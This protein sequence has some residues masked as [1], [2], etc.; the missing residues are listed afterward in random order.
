LIAVK[1]A[2]KSYQPE[3]ALFCPLDLVLIL[4][5]PKKRRQA[6]A[7]PSSLTDQAPGSFKPVPLSI[8]FLLSFF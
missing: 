5:L 8:K 1:R 3:V 4:H 7:V 2:K 6:G